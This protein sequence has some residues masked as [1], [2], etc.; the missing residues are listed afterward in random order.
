MYIVL[1]YL[2]H[3]SPTPPLGEAGW[4]SC[5]PTPPLGEVGVG[6]YFLIYFLPFVITIP[7]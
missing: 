3:S 5:S 1:K 7:L 2:Y 6:L 4:G